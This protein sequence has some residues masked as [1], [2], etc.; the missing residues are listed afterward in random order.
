MLK[1]VVVETDPSG[2]LFLAPNPARNLH[3]H[4]EESEFGS[5]QDNGNTV[6]MNFPR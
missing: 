1:I 6:Q 4:M 2:K 5:R 3:Q